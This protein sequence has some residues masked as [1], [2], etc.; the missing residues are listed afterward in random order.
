[1][2]VV[3]VLSKEGVGLYSE[4]LVHFGHVHVVNKVDQPFVPRGT[5][6]LA[7]L[8]LEGFLQNLIKT[9]RLINS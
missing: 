1:M 5:I 4:V 9:P 2:S 8:F 7:R 3:K 6:T